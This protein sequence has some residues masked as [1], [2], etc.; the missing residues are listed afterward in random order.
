MVD[1]VGFSFFHFR[2]LVVWKIAVR[3]AR[4][5]SF[6][7]GLHIEISSQ[8]ARTSSFGPFKLVVHPRNP[9]HS[10]I[11]HIPL[12][13]PHLLLQHQLR[14]RTRNLF[15]MNAK[16]AHPRLAHPH[17]T[18]RLKMALINYPHHIQSDF[19]PRRCNTLLHFLH[20]HHL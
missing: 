14:P 10:S 17:H 20:Y 15:L 5:A 4:F 3:C 2:C 18:H 19:S 13:R 8:R 1:I 6:V 11:I 9:P 16:I 12:L 7:I